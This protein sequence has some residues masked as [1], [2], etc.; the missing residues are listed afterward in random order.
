M[1]PEQ[2]MA[3]DRLKAALCA[4][5]HA[6]KRIDAALPIILYTDWSYMALVLCWARRG[7]MA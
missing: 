4:E 6:I 3:Y 2:Q 7:Q 1:G 5:G